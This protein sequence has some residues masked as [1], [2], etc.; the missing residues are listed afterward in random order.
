MTSWSRGNKNE[1]KGERLMKKPGLADKAKGALLKAAGEIEQ[2][3][4]N[5]KDKLTGRQ[6]TLKGTDPKPATPRKRSTGSK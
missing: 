4:D 5:V 6:K 3:V 1:D 2:G